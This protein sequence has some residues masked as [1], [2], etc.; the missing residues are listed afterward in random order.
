ML[1]IALVAT[2]SANASAFGLFDKLCNRGCDSGCDIPVEPV[3]GCEPVCEP[4]CGYDAVDPCCAPKRGLLDKLFHR[5][6]GCCDSGCDPEP[7]CG[8]EPVCEP[9]CGLEPAYGSD[10]GCDDPCGKRRPLGGFFHKLFHHNKSCCD[11]GC[12]IVEPACGCEPACGFEVA[13]SCGCGH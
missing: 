13:P 8:C 1:A 12:E 4:A 11:S 6:G 5:D 7:V 9:V 10:C 3:C 2:S